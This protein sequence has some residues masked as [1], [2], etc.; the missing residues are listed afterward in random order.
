MMIPLPLPVSSARSRHGYEGAA[1]LVNLY[2]APQ[3]QQA[4]T[5]H[6]LYAVD[7]MTPWLTPAVGRVWAMLATETRLYGVTGTKVWSIDLNDTVTTLGTL[8]VEGFVTFARNRRSPNVQVGLVATVPAAYYV[9][10]GTSMTLVTDPDLQGT[11]SAIEVSDGYFIIATNLMRF[12]ITGEDNAT[13]IES[14]NF[15]RAQ[16]QPD[17]ILRVVATESEIALFGERSIEWWRNDPT[18]GISFPYQLAANIDVGLLARGTLTRLGRLVYWIADDGT[19]R[20]MEG[21]GGSVVSTPPVERA[22]ASV[23]GDDIAA[24]SWVSHQTGHQFVAFVS[25]S[26]A[27]VHDVRAGTWH[28]RKSWNRNTWRASAA[29]EWQGR[30]ILGD[31]E[32]GALYRLDAN[33]HTEGGD[34]IV[35]EAWTPPLASWPQMAQVHRVTLDVVP[36]VGIAET[37]SER[38]SEPVVRISWSDDGGQTW[39]PERAASLGRAG[40]RMPR[41][42]WHR[43]GIVR[44]GSRTFRFRA[45]A[46]VVRCLLQAGADVEVLN[47]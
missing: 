3:D 38:N 29:V 9:I 22:I 2:A 31:R 4:K 32:T 11:P 21:Y 34:P 40:N 30:V 45:D 7:G 23:A 26:W 14:L 20:V 41:V 44:R 47:R 1:R 46:D 24:L 33:V 5:A 18:P 35:C 27:W 13:A 16:K 25:P 37:E 28:E 17:E 39:S 8:S 12:H 6:A 10:E 43:F 15:G 19:V 36:G 42:E